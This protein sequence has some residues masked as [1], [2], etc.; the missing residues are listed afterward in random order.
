LVQQFWPVDVHLIGKEILWFHAVYW[1]AMLISLGLPL[2]KQIFAHGWWTAEG[3][4]MSKTM[5]N[6]IDLSR[7][8]GLSQTYS[9]DAL[10]FYLLRVAPFGSDMD[11][12]EA[13]FLKS[14]NELANVLGNCLNRTLKMIGKYRGGV[15][16]AVTHAPTDL[17]QSLMAAIDRLPQQLEQA[18][19]KLELQQAVLAP[20]ELARQTNG[21][22]DATAPFSLAKD[23]AKAEQLSTVLHLSVQAIYRALIGLIPILPDKAADG[24]RQLGVDAAGIGKDP[25]KLWDHLPLGHKV[26]EG[27]PLF[28]RIEPKN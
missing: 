16:G 13:D 12:N 26:N 23:P 14:F 20:M 1:P 11:F 3:K 21:Y 19:A 27:S 8:L 7:V 25:A 24:L 28:P 18:Y 15:L 6:F 17:D 10:R 9:L 4:K 22:I 2:P 5:G